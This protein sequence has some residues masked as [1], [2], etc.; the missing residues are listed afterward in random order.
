MA[1]SYI[2]SPPLPSESRLVSGLL[3]VA[4]VAPLR[5]LRHPAPR[6]GRVWTVVLVL[7]LRQRLRCRCVKRAWY[8]PLHRGTPICRR[9]SFRH[10][11]TQPP[12]GRPIRLLNEAVTL[13]CT[14]AVMAAAAGE[15]TAS[16]FSRLLTR[17]ALEPC[18]V[19]TEVR[20][21]PHTGHLSV[22]QRTRLLSMLMREQAPSHEARL[23]RRF[24]ALRE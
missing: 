14:L 20:L 15:A 13:L 24:R 3:L 21:R 12:P 4:V 10:A 22:M 16:T 2:P 18:S 23:L 17:R 11:S 1:V 8:P 19:W 5:A 6:L 9:L 7:Y